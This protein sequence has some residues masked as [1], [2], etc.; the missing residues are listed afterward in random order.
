MKVS[1]KNSVMGSMD[2]RIGRNVLVT[3]IWNGCHLAVYFNNS[4]ESSEIFQVTNGQG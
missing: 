2:D 3:G 4:G 1:P